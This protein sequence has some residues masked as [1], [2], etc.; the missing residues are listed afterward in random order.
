M[1]LLLVESL[2]L[3]AAGTA[4]GLLFARL[5]TALFLGT[6]DI[7]VSIPLNLDFHYDWRVF[8][9]AAIVALFTGVLMGLAPA[10]RVTRAR[11][12]AAP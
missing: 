8:A 10:V 1:R 6:L 2:L 3:A 5:A 9:Y 7:G 4:A 12:R 11:G